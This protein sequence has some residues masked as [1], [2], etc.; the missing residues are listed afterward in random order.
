MWYCSYFGNI[1]ASFYL[2][3][4]DQESFL[5]LQLIKTP[6]R[7]P[8]DPL[9]KIGLASKYGREKCDSKKGGLDFVQGSKNGQCPCVS[10]LC[11]CHPKV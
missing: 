2:G 11:R 8:N 10:Q 9:Q 6:M 1:A 4:F 3:F 5:N 7:K